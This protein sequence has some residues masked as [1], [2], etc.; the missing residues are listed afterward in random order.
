M[1]E[2]HVVRDRFHGTNVLD[3]RTHSR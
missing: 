1:D 2:V 3:S